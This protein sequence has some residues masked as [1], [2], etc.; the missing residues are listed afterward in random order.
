MQLIMVV[1]GESRDT[2]ML[3]CWCICHRSFEA[4]LF[5]CEPSAKQLY[6]R[7][8]QQSARALGPGTAVIVKKNQRATSASIIWSAAMSSASP[9]T[10][11]KQ[12]GYVGALEGLRATHE[13]SWTPL[14]VVGDSQLILRQLSKCHTPRNVRLGRL[15][16]QARRLGG[17][18]GVRRWIRHLR[19]ST[20]W[21][22]RHHGHPDQQSSPPPNPTSTTCRARAPTWLR[23]C[24]LASPTLCSTFTPVRKLR[25]LQYSKRAFSGTHFIVIIR[26]HAHL[27]FSPY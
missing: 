2:S 21:R 7:Q 23:L 19:G 14:D 27:K 20:R 18:L 13:H 16:A 12:A 3:R 4:Q 17:L 25:R 24:T 1:H 5:E 8:A 10:T 26:V 15:Y 22:M 9:D 11:N 6:S